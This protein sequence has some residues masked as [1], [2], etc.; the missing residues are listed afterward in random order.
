VKAVVDAYDGDVI[1]YTVDEEDPVL[2][3]YTKMFPDLFVEKSKIPAE[4]WEH[5]RYPLDYF[6]IQAQMYLSY[7]MSQPEVF[8]NREDMWLFP[9]E[10]YEGNEEQMDPYYTIMQLNDEKE[11]FLL[12]LPFTPVSKNNMIAWMAARSDAENYGKLILYEFPKKELIYGPMQIEARIDQ[13]PK[14]SEVLTLWNQQGSSVIRGNLL[15]IPLKN[16][17]LYVEPLY[18]QSEQSK[19]PELK[20]VIAA[21]NNAIVMEDTLEEALNVVFGLQKNPSRTNGLENLDAN[22]LVKEAVRS[23]EAGRTALK[24]GD[25]SGYGAKQKELE[26]ILRDLEKSA[27]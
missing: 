18:L 21:Y 14:I 27:K 25:W 16:S 15:V 20:R 22:S 1:F 26:S 11:E 9:K 12:I 7:H 5:F 2:Q 13:D 6:K 17:I 19:M 10:I 3:T 24:N 23:F 8:Y 4:L